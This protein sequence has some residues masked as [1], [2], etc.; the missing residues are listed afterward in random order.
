MLVAV[1]GGSFDPPHVAHVITA[2]YVLAVGGFDRL[3]VVPVYEHPFGK[4]LAPF[5]ERLAMCRLAFAGLSAV[6]VSDIE[7][8][9]GKP[10]YTERTLEALRER[11]PG[12]SYRFV[13][14]SDALAETGAW[15]A[16]D[17]VAE[18]APPFVVARVGHHRPGLGPA[19]LPDVSSTRVRE[20]L[21]RRGDP[22]AAR[23]L[24]W[25]VP[26]SILAYIEERGLYR[27]SPD[28]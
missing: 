20:L 3:I 28:G 22:G 18:L 21:A 1:Y 16:F 24:G 12:A 10:S 19:V 5:D 2:S 23:E 25:L 8:S 4:P 9:L 7:A 11:T 27:E 6:E 13:M 26:A 14:G 17:R 15:H